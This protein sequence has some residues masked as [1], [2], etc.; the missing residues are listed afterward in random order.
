MLFLKLNR[1]DINLS[2]VKKGLKF[3]FFS[4][5]LLLTVNNVFSN[6][7]DLTAIDRE[8]EILRKAY[9]DVVFKY[10]FNRTVDDFEISVIRD[11]QNNILYRAGGRY[12]RKEQL[13]YKEKFWQLL[14]PFPKSL[15]DPSDFT[16][17]ELARVMMFGSTKN[18]KSGRIAGTAFFDALYDCE[19]REDVEKHIVSLNFLGNEISVHSRIKEPLEKVENKIR[20]AASYD[21]AVKQFLQELGPVSAYSWRSVRD[22]SGKSFHSMGLAVDIMPKNLKGKAIYWNWEKSRGNEKWMLVPLSDRWMPPEEVIRIFESEGF[23]WGGMWPI[24]DNMHFEHRPE[25][26]LWRDK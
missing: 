11:G 22:T 9:P 17:E 24:W 18:R 4:L 10:S 15:K 7:R 14:Y 19:T 3:I 1:I 8:V 20:S 12:L 25:L 6:E 2:K 21:R 13:S 23:T 16:E 26:L 5:I